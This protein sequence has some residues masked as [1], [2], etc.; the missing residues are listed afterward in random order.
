MA[1]REAAWV[2]W[3][4]VACGCVTSAPERALPPEVRAMEATRARHEGARDEA[5]RVSESGE[6]YALRLRHNPGR[7]GAPAFE[8]RARGR[9]E[10]V[11][12][13]ASTEELAAEFA[14]W[15]EQ[16]GV[17]EERVASA[18]FVTEQRPDTRGA[19]WPV[20]A[21]F[22][23]ADGAEPVARVRVRVPREGCT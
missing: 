1:V 18:R 13:D 9:W 16:S 8:V 23:S 4:F 20:L 6:S 3:L 21:V 14:A 19:I 11:W 12:L 7:C 2:V 17:G 15:G 5:L 22:E 10:R